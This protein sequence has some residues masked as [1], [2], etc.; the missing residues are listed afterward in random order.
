MRQVGTI[1]GVGRGWLFEYRQS[2]ILG[3]ENIDLKGN[4]TAC[5]FTSLQGEFM[6]RTRE[7]T[8]S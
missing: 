7:K 2:E 6:E 1:V 3:C 5:P 4:T 8:T